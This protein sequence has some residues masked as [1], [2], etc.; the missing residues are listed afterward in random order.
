MKKSLYRLLVSMLVV[1]IVGSFSLIACKQEVAEEEKVAEEE[2]A[3][4]EVAEEEVAEEPLVIG[5]LCP[6]MAIQW[7]QN[8][9][10]AY[11]EF[12]KMNNFE[13]M[14]M[15]AAMKTEV[16]MDQTETLIS[17][18]VDGIIVC[19]GQ[20]DIG[21][22]VHA[23][24]KEEGIPSISESLR[25]TDEDG[26]LVAPVVELDAYNVGSRASEWIVDNYESLGMEIADDYSDVGFF[27]I[28]SGILP[29]EQLRAAGVLDKFLEGMPDFPE[30]NIYE[31]DT[32]G[33]TTGAQEEAYNKMT[34]TIVSRPDIKYWFGVGC[35]DTYGQGAARA[36]EA[37]GMTDTAI[38]ASLGG[39]QALVEW[40]AGHTKPWYAATYFTAWDCAELITEG[41]MLMI[42]EGVPIEELWPEYI[43]EGQKYASRTFT[44]NVM[45]PDNY[46]EQL[47]D[48]DRKII[49]GE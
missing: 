34:G 25:A 10:A 48:F 37:A 11:R 38:V 35:L 49:F 45:T 13:V 7:C 18:Q 44:G 6:T 39:E 27:Y 46:N 33:T 8:I 5:Y 2:V 14:T 1:A 21:A 3:E 20:T 31:L 42:R 41:L 36:L 4:E 29:I 40:A 47:N 16:V 23:R 24:C 28:Y 43:A 12:A 32:A 19:V 17:Q 30:N 26:N 15:D 22:A 9:D